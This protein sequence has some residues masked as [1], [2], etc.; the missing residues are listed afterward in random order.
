M[1]LLEKLVEKSAQDREFV[2]RIGEHLDAK[3]QAL[4]PGAS[5]TE[6]LER[7]HEGVGLF[8]SVK[9]ASIDYCMEGLSEARGRGSISL[10]QEITHRI[11]VMANILEAVF[12]DLACGHERNAQVGKRLAW[13]FPDTIGVTEDDARQLKHG[14]S[15][16]W[17][18]LYETWN[19]AFVTGNVHNL[20]LVYPKLLIPSVLLAANDKFIF[21]RVLALWLSLHFYVMSDLAKKPQ[22]RFPEQTALAK[23]WGKVNLRFSD[24]VEHKKNVQVAPIATAAT[25][26]GKFIDGLTSSIDDLTSSVTSSMA[27][28]HQDLVTKFDSFPSFFGPD[29]T[30]PA[31]A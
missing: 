22:L 7:I 30:A 20:Y 8:V 16:E 3:S 4:T 1:V 29:Q 9:K 11:G 14:Y 5:F 26:F 24:Y 18:Q 17:T 10:K 19:L 2:E 25:E 6:R 31:V 12:A 15:D 28:L 27:K 23:L 13:E 21:H